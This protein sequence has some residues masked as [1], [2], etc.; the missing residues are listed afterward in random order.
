MPKIQTGREDIQV[1]QN[2]MHP[3]RPV[4]LV[5]VG[6]YGD[7]DVKA[8]TQDEAIDL[9]RALLTAAGMPSPYAF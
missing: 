2:E 8:L 9:A 3:T 4:R 7:E 1:S 6:K 5:L